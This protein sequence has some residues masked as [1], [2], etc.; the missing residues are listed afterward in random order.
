VPLVP[1]IWAMLI[2]KH[3]GSAEYFKELVEIRERQAVNVH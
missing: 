2:Q 1:T 3:L